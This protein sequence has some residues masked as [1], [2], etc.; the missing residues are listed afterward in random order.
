M[1]V[2]SRM[3]E[4]LNQIDP[5]AW[6]RFSSLL[7]EG[8]SL[9]P[10]ERAAW[11]DALAPDDR[12]LRALLESAFAADGD[13]RASRATGVPAL[14][15]D[16]DEPY[17]F[18]GGRRFGPYE[19]TVPLGRGGMGEVWRAYR[20]DD[21]SLRE[22]ALKLP[23]TWLLSSATRLRLGRE[24]E[25]LAALDHPN[26]VRLQDAG[27][28]E[29]GQP[30][31]ALECVE[32]Q[33]IDVYCRERRLGVA[34]RLDLFAQVLEAVESAHA[35]LV[36]HRDLKPSNILV[37]GDGT[38]KLL[39]FGIA[40]LLDE[41]G[42]GEETALTRMS[43]RPATLDYAAPEQLNGGS[44]SV[45]TDVY[46]LGIVLYELLCGQRPFPPRQTVRERL[47]EPPPLA[48]ERANDAARAASIGGLSPRQLRRALRGDLD[49]ILAYALAV[50]PRRRYR[51]VERM[52]DDIARHR[53]SEPIVARR[54]TWLE[55]GWMFGIRHRV[56]LATVSLFM[57][58]VSVGIV[59]SLQQARRAEHEAERANASRDFLL[60]ILAAN[61]RIG[62]TTREPGTA[63]ARDLLDNIVAKLD[64]RLA[65]QPD[66]QLELLKRAAWIYRAWF[67]REQTERLQQR[68]RELVLKR[69]GPQDPRLIQSLLD[70]ASTDMDYP[71]R[72]DAESLLAEADRLIEA[73]G[74][75]DTP[76]EAKWLLESAR[77]RIPAIGYSEDAIAKLREA[78]AIYER[79]DPLQADLPWTY[80]H[81]ANS[82]IQAGR[83]DE[84]E[85]ITRAALAKEIGKNVRNDW[86]IATQWVRLAHIARLKG[87][88]DTALANY[89]KSEGLI[90]RTYGRDIYTFWEVEFWRATLLD[91]RGDSAAA[92]ARFKEG[93]ADLVALRSPQL[94]EATGWFRTAYARFLIADGRPAEALPLLQEALAVNYSFRPARVQRADVQVLLASVQES[95]GHPEQARALYDAAAEDYL[96]RNVPDAPQ[97]L[98]A[99]WARADFRCR[100]GE[101][102]DAEPE[103]REIARLGAAAPSPSSTQAL[104]RL[105]E[106]AAARG[107]AADS[108][109]LADAAREQ[110]MAIRGLYDPRLRARMLESLRRLGVRDLPAEAGA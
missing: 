32:G 30:W 85:A 18:A 101:F 37:T 62:A 105:A 48:S 63:T 13:L 5:D 6:P 92:D 53:R 31:L 64:T 65:N 78:A 9:P 29:D 20:W 102:A 15:A 69:F 46:A 14:R 89:E 98:A 2:A 83:L 96:S 76:L 43:G 10:A 39:D 35:N 77:F 110:F 7:D 97:V 81:L 84:A 91:W 49:A 73:S 67:Q 56:A 17:L 88:L 42:S 79:R 75:R 66:T 82:L 94:A 106:I 74:R 27:I 8:L 108:E 60:D 28:A 22:I 26:I 16:V 54:V 40:K 21:A 52:A 23:H 58:V 68:Y 100:Q 59:T 44:L 93:L 19:I 71:D 47:A 45:A 103:L 4:T 87:D 38:V 57:I 95:L 11:L 12:P 99:R 72:H 36:V 86:F 61:D 34:A 104:L 3:T 24:K 107:N 90:L 25:I 80:A 33:P 1:Q 109:R 55:R 51:S 41:S 50:D 70:E